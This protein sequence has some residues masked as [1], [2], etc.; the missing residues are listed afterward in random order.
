MF[1]SGKELLT[2]SMA[3]MCESKKGEKTN[4]GKFATVCI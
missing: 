1:I 2:G 3:L 4:L